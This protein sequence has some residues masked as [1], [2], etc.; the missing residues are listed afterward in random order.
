MVEPRHLVYPEIY[1][2][3]TFSA[4][5]THTQMKVLLVP[6]A[7][8]SVKQHV[9]CPSSSTV[10]ECLCVDVRVCVYV[11]VIAYCDKTDPFES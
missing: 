6:G 9:A 4:T 3:F 2:H 7:E 8:K 10:P 5:H 1:P 11:C